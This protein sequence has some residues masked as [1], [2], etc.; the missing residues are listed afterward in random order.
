MKRTALVVLFVLTFLGSIIQA[1]AEP[2]LSLSPLTILPGQTATLDLSL[3]NG[4]ESYA[5]VNGKILLPEGVTVD[6]VSKGELLTDNF[7]IDWE[8]FSS[9]EGDGA[10]IIAY[11]EIDSF[12][13]SSGTLLTLNLLIEDGV[14]PDIN[15]VAFASTNLNL[16][17]NSKHALSILNGSVS[18]LHITS[19]GGDTDGD[20]IGD[21][22]DNCPF[23]SNEFQENT[24]GD[25]FGDACDNCP[26]LAGVSQI[27]SDGDGYGDDC[28]DCPDDPE[29]IEPGVCGCGVVETDLDD[30]GMFDC[31]E[32]DHGLNSDVN[33]SLDDL[34]NDGYNNLREYLSNTDP[35]SD[36]SQP[37]QPITFHVNVSAIPPLSGLDEN[38]SQEAPFTSLQDAINAAGQN[39]IIKVAAGIYYETLTFITEI[40]LQGGWNIDFSQRWDFEN[41]G[42][43]PTA[44]YQTIIDGEG[45]GSCITL[46]YI[47][48]QAAIDGFTIQNGETEGYGGGISNDHSSPVI[49]NCI[50]L[51]NSTINSG[52]GGGIDNFYSSPT[53]D[54][55]VFSGNST[56]TSGGGILNRYSSSPTITKCVFIGNTAHNGGG[57]YNVYNSSP[58]IDSCIF[59]GN[60]A[61][62][63][64]GISNH[65]G[66]SPIVITNC[67]LSSNDAGGG[68]GIYCG[69]NSSTKVINCTIYGNQATWQGG[70]I[71]NMYTPDT[72]IINSIIW[73]NT[74]LGDGAEIYNEQ[75]ILT[76]SYT[77]L[78]GG[79]LGI[80]NNNGGSVIDNGNNIEE[81]P[82]FVDPDGPDDIIGTKDDNLHL[83]PESP[84]IDSGDP[85]ET[86][87]YDYTGGVNLFVDTV[88]NLNLG[89]TIWITDGVNTESNTV[90]NT[91]ETLNTITLANSFFNTYLVSDGSYVYSLSSNFSDEPEPNGGRINIGAY[92][93]TPEAT[94][95]VM[96]TF[97]DINLEA[98]I[99]AAIGIPTGPIYN[100]D[101]EGLT[102]LNANLA[103][104]TDLTGLEYCTDLS[105]LDLNANQIS[106]ISPLSGLTNLTSLDLNN[107]QISDISP[108]SGLINL[109]YLELAGNQI[110]DISAL[111]SLTNLTDLALYGNHIIDIS[112]LITN[113]GIDSEDNLYINENPLNCDSILKKI[114]ILLARGVNVTWT[115]NDTDKDDDGILDVDEDKNQDGVVDADETDPCNPDSDFDGMPDGWEVAKNTNPLVDDA[116]DDND[117][118]GYSNL[119]EYL[120]NSDPWN[121]QDVP[122]LLADFNFNNAVDGSDLA[123]LIG[124]YGRDDCSVADPC[125][126]DLNFDG[127]IDGIDLFLFSEDF[128]RVE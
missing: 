69:E 67:I 93:G 25:A 56:E 7:S 121:D 87:I 104:I 13:A 62:S 20:G 78:A 100:T 48:E 68:G 110:I 79:I 9:G 27:D 112:A 117:N 122:A 5:G 76:I 105:F 36:S 18:V 70:G 80:V 43:E 102:A 33:D 3:L 31:W 47:S 116:F 39:D 10:L 125:D 40:T 37:T 86:L 35:N 53:I 85:V 44:G 55:C 4:E 82:L 66:S 101:L 119:R 128:G 99:R 74:T 90:L 16:L 114:P 81:D 41:D 15:D 57:I 118:D 28:D 113:I 42:I 95:Y 64:G 83:R 34:D 17:I 59:I 123:I 19:P 84:G 6:S 89:D 72:T 30:D 24:D 98:K 106:D 32:D 58:S 71:L 91:S 75:G 1:H 107:N 14:S 49:S 127:Y 54:N 63:G 29:K 92:G 60:S 88:T 12:T 46:N 126:C 21:A 77:D 45:Y 22:A 8:I 11:S 26:Y 96:V 109:T 103:N 50:F 111:S 2:V 52:G 94:S 38:G 23:V 51:N 61:N 97:P 108:L 124:E 115:D 65:F 73:G 120:S